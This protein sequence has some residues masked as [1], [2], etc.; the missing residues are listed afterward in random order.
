[1]R[2]VSVSSTAPACETAPLPAAALVLLCAQPLTRIATDDVLQKD[3]EVP[4]RLGDPP[5]SAHAKEQRRKN[6]LPDHAS[7]S[8]RT[9]A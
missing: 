1:M 7:R 3:G 2:T 4:F 9:A 6:D 5:S 8:R